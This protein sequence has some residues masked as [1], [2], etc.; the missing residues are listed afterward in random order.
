MSTKSSRTGKTGIDRRKFLQTATATGGMMIVGPQAVRGSQANSRLELGIIGSG[1]RGEFIGKLFEQHGNA[2]V[3]ALHDYFAS[4]VKGLGELLKVEA[5]RRYTGLDGY[6]QLLESK[7]DAVAI[8]SPPYFHPEQAIATMR[9]GK[10]LFLAKP[11]GVDVPGIMSIVEEAKKVRGKLSVIVDFQARNDPYF[12][13]AAK[14]VREGAIGKIVGGHVYYHARP[15]KH[16]KKTNP[17]VQR[18]QHWLFDKALAGDIIVEQNIHVLDMAHMFIN[19]H[20][21]KAQG[22]GRRTSVAQVGDYWDEFYVTYWYP[23]DIRIDFSGLQFLRG[24]GDLCARI[25]GEIGTADTHYMGKVT[26]TGDQPWPG[27]DTA[28]LY[29]SGAVNNIKDFSA[30][31]FEGK[32]LFDTVEPSAES[33]LAGV[34]GRMAAYE[35]RIVTWDEMMKRKP[36]L[37]AKLQL[38]PNGPEL[39]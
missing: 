24:Y 39:G 10:H 36:R 6:R 4:R 8:E 34:L 19:A 38:P 17:Q 2:K 15:N 35:G 25:Y 14:R 9:A 7:V 3:V 23:N 1:S 29:T 13:E 31:I 33:C 37:D 32:P 11:M 28:G 18:L 26:I 22:T 21:L 20:P 5:S 27:G 30:S 12:R 16:Q